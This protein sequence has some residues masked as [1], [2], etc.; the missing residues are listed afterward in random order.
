MEGREHGVV[1][2]VELVAGRRTHLHGGWCTSRRRRERLSVV[3]VA[4]RLRYRQADT[5]VKVGGTQP[6]RT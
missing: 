2:V 1:E 4:G 6:S 5:R 3:L